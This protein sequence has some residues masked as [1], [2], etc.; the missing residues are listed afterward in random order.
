MDKV[1]E[2]ELLSAYLDGELTAAEQ[3][4][5][6][7][8][9]ATDPAAR[10]WLDEMRALSHT[11]QSLPQEKVGED[12][13]P[14]VLRMAERRLLSDSPPAEPAAQ[15][16][17]PSQPFW[18]ETLRGMLSRRALVWSGLAVAIAV[19]MMIYKPDAGKEVARGGKTVPAP[20]AAQAKSDAAKTA[21]AEP[22]PPELRAASPA[23]P[24]A[25]AAPAKARASSDAGK[26]EG[27]KESKSAETAPPPPAEPEKAADKAA[28]V[29]HDADRSGLNAA[30]NNYA[31]EQTKKKLSAPQDRS[32]KNG[33]R[34][35]VA[36]GK[37]KDAINQS[38]VATA[39]KP[40]EFDK[41]GADRWGRGSGSGS[42]SG[43]GPRP[44][45]ERA[46]AGANNY[47]P[48][49]QAPPEEPSMPAKQPPAR[50]YA[51]SA[52]RAPRPFV[53]ATLGVLVVHCDV[54]PEA[55]RQKVFNKLLAGDG[56]VGSPR[57]DGKDGGAMVVDAEAT[58]AQIRAVLSQLMARQASFPQVVVLPATGAMWQ[59]PFGQ[60]NFSRGGGQ[61]QQFSSNFAFQNGGGQ[62]GMGAGKAGMAVGPG[63]LGGGQATQQ[64]GVAQAGGGAA[65]ARSRA[66]GNQPSP[67][68][69]VGSFSRAM[70]DDLKNAEQKE[71]GDGSG[72]AETY[73]APQAAP[74]PAATVPA[75]S[76]QAIVQ[77]RRWQQQ[78]QQNQAAPLYRVLFVLRRV[79]G[80][81][82]AVEPAPA[83]NM[84]PNN[85]APNNMAPN[86]AAP[87]SA[88]AK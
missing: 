63:G 22:A 61:N 81:Q 9:L 85:M 33:V 65:N 78:A 62:G 49:A 31:G 55:D 52:G 27:R 6:E 54:S 72:Q 53:P 57:G 18:R 36:A 83:A 67:S 74:A 64:K 32:A 44:A 1:P 47:A 30:R 84:A 45:A 66:A 12:L 16:A 4:R 43:S 20:T 15:P 40:K 77:S 35:Q 19:M 46:L 88:P 34:D 59:Q 76:A 51:K 28:D 82:P 39:E 80:P 87:N 68:A 17:P 69:D 21:T 37:E 48:Q 58:S 7:Q 50:S 60:F 79:D 86:N 24:A 25:E 3:A 26:G 70:T 29:I 41:R 14:H 73:G 75:A 8:L 2:S 13:G 11:L 42:G 71:S 5:V 38:P 56:I 10:R 23:T